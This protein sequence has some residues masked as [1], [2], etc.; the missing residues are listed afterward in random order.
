MRA[1][2][3]KMNEFVSNFFWE[4]CVKVRP[5][6]IRVAARYC[7]APA[8]A[9]DIV[10]DALI[11]AAEFADLDMDRLRPFLVS[12]VKRLCADDARRRMVANRLS[13]HTR[14]LPSAGDDP[15]ET[16]CDQ[17]EARWLASRLRLLNRR[18]RLVVL[19]VADGFGHG[20]IAERLNTTPRAAQSAL[21]RIRRRIRMTWLSHE[22]APKESGTTLTTR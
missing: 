11:R 5:Y 19:M 20:E 7:A 15:A 10:H 14:L 16:A 18:D 3:V 2:P 1:Q 12:V 4:E 17:A 13:G 8:Q 22:S 9:E 21:C 6:L